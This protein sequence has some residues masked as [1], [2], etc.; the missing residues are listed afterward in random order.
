[1]R[2]PLTATLPLVVLG[3]AVLAAGCGGGGGG[4]STTSAAPTHVTV[5]QTNT[6]P[7]T[8]GQTETGPTTSTSTETE[9]TGTTAP[10]PPPPPPPTTAST[11]SS[12]TPTVPTTPEPSRH[13]LLGLQDDAL[14]TSAEP[15]AW[16]TTKALGPKIIRY[17]IAWDQVAPARPK[18]PQDPGDPAYDWSKADRIAVTAG[19]IGAQVLFT[20]VQSPR[21]A[22]GG[23]DPN[24]APTKPADY[25]DFCAAV[26]HRYSGSYRPKGAAAALPEV[27][28]YTVWN[29]ANRG[30]YFQPQGVHG[31]I[32]P[33]R[34][35]PLYAACQASIHAQNPKGQAAFGPLA[36]RGAQHGT[37]PLPFIAAYRAAGGVKPDVFALNPYMEG[38][39]PEYVPQEK[40]AGGV[41]TIRNLDQL[42][43]VLR[44]W[45]GKP[46]DIWLT[47]FAWR[48]AP[49]PRI[50]TIAPEL[51]A[52][53][54]E[55][56]VSLIVDRE[57]Y[58]DLLVWFLVRDE[59]ATSY[60]R[61]GLVTFGWHR[62]PAFSVF[63]RLARDVS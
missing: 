1:M 7:S 53:L 45:A 58:V 8:T 9:P 48:T 32:A 13:L 55:Q 26:A 14:L 25:G 3:L 27:D 62:K 35:A 46:V 52:T 50:G 37:G 5:T 47:E 38:L 63:Q 16:P 6:I 12:T 57:P 49:T 24:V 34:Y 23:H 21:W 42:E 40:L 39:L 61:S 19:S 33:R 60:W 10:P 54:L 51:Q 31:E 56:T 59:S 17:N 20:I 28:R 36:S 4:S 29:E 15:N 22:N 41:I 44:A 18:H 30:Q 43:G 2:P 11:S